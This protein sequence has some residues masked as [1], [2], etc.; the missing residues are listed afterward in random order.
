MQLGC[1]YFVEMEWPYLTVFCLFKKRK[2]QNIRKW[3]FFKNKYSM[4]TPSAYFFLFYASEF[5]LSQ[6]WA[7]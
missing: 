2:Q 5:F 6:A 4:L 3:W 1:G 7:E